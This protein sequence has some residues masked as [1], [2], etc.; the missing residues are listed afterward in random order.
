MFQVIS[1]DK[2]FQTIEKAIVSE[3]ADIVLILPD[4]KNEIISKMRWGLFSNKNIFQ[5]EE[6]TV[7]SY[8][9]IAKAKQKLVEVHEKNYPFFTT[10]AEEYFQKNSF[11]FFI[12]ENYNVSI[13]KV[14]NPK[15]V[16]NIEK[17]IAL[18]LPDSEQLFKSL[19]V[20]DM[21]GFDRKNDWLFEYMDLYDEWRYKVMEKTYSYT[22]QIGGQGRWIQSDYDDYIGQGNLELGDAGSVYFYVDGSGIQG[23]VD[24]Y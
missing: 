3:L 22:W 24:M 2:M 19:I 4:C 9:I 10:K 13:Q 16:E 8:S 1:S 15:E 7:L 23:S 14:K 5:S 20:G 17:I 21:L 6:E 18:T 12:D 11:S